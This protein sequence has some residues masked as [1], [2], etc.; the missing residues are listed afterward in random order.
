[1]NQEE[2]KERLHYD[3]MTGVFVWLKGRNRGLKAGHLRSDGYVRISIGRKAYMAHRLAWLYVYGYFPKEIDHKNGVKDDNRIE[4]LRE[5]THSQN[6][7][8]SPP[9]NRTLPRGVYLKSRCAG[10]NKYM[11]T[12][13][14]NGKRKHLGY[15]STV[16]E[17]HEAYC[18]E[19]HKAFGEYARI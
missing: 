18:S 2:L 17:A 10:D 11:A 16:E 5:C 15:F 13:V 4:N 6:I 7:A 19:K 12:I 1:M 9:R 14:S 3:K 8:N